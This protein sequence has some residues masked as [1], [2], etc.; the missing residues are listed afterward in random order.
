VLETRL[1]KHAMEMVDLLYQLIQPPQP[2]ELESRSANS[3]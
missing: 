1:R 3:E 2:G